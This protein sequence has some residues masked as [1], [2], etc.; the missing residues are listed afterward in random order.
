MFSCPARNSALLHSIAIRASATHVGDSL[1]QTAPSH[2]TP[3]D[4]DAWSVK[5]SIHLIKSN[6]ITSNHKQQRRRYLQFVYKDRSCCSKLT[7]LI[8]AGVCLNNVVIKPHVS[9]CHAVLCQCASF[10][11]TY[12][13]R[14][15]KS[16]HSFQ[17]LHQTVLASHPL[18]GQRQTYLIQ[19]HCH[20]LRDSCL[21]KIKPA[22]TVCSGWLLGE[23]F[24]ALMSQYALGTISYFGRCP[25]RVTA[26]IN[27]FQQKTIKYQILSETVATTT[28][29]HRLS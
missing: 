21:Q 1:L 4:C 18:G 9:D 28:Y 2:Q 14:R 23:V 8:F 26:Y 29:S 11:R 6:L 15:A 27:S 24:V 20:L 19:T 3:V 16:L 5:F 7:R 12:R 25:I 10:I 17:V 13:R 22:Q